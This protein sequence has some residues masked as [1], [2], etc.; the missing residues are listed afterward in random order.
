M[1][2][3]RRPRRKAAQPVSTEPAGHGAQ[4]PARREPRPRNEEAEES[5]KEPSRKDAQAPSARSRPNQARSQLAAGHEGPR[6]GSLGL[7]AKTPKEGSPEEPSKSL[8]KEAAS[9]GQRAPLGGS[10][11]SK[12]R[13]RGGSEKLYKKDIDKFIDGSDFEV[14]SLAWFSELSKGTFKS[15]A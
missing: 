15:A 1:R 13:G 12:R 7:G 5:S 6:G 2:A 14:E 11:G 9:R 8:R 3:Q 4:G 10:P